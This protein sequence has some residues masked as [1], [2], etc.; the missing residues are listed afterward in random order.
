MERIRIFGEVQAAHP[1]RS[2]KKLEGTGLP[3]GS[4][5]L[6]TLLLDVK[7]ARKN[8]R[9][10]EGQTEPGVQ[11]WSILLADNSFCVSPLPSIVLLVNGIDPWLF[12]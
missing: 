11:V 10:T 6:P 12:G 2:F 1:K 9:G 8:I 4:K 3:F 5:V 7:K